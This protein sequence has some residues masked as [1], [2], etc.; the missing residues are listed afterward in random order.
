[1]ASKDELLANQ[2]VARPKVS[3]KRYDDIE[4]Q[5][6]ALLGRLNRLDEKSADRSHKSALTL[7]NQ[8]FRVAH[9][10]QRIEI[11]KAASWLI[12]VIEANRGSSGQSD[13]QPAEAN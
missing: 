9:V 5:R 6:L 1:M 3:R 11:L 10:D 7:L 8:K 13:Q 2:Q 12:T 4:R